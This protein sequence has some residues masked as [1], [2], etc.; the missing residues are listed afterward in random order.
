LYFIT[1][2]QLQEYYSPMTSIFFRSV[3]NACMRELP[4]KQTLPAYVLLDE[5][6][7]LNIPN[8]VSTANTIRGYQV[9]LSV[10]LQSISQLKARY[11]DEA[12]AI[13]GGFTTYLTYAGADPDTATFFER[14]AGKVRE[15]QRSKIEDP[16]PEQYKEYNLINASE[17]RTITENQTLI[18]SGNR[19]PILIPSKGYFEVPA[20]N[21]KTKMKSALPSV[22]KP[23][24]LEYVRL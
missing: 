22:T 15:R 1:P 2:P 24:Q 14:V 23:P 20:M 8:F 3:F 5:F 6:G 4:S 16:T 7:H 9:S 18:I 21:R 19:Q 17:V 11:R 13:Q 10:V 12:D